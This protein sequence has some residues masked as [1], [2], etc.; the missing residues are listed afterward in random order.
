LSLCASIHDIKVIVGV[1]C[2]N[3]FYDHFSKGHRSW[4][5]EHVSSDVEGES[6]EE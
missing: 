2:V 1:D 3:C 6:S 4:G 5:L